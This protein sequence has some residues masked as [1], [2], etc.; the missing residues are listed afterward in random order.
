MDPRLSLGTQTMGLIAI[1]IMLKIRYGISLK[2]S[3]SS[4]SLMNTELI[5]KFT[6]LPE[7]LFQGW[8]WML[9]NTCLRIHRVWRRRPF[10]RTASAHV[11]QFH[12]RLEVHWRGNKM[13]RSLRRWWCP[14]TCKS[15]LQESTRRQHRWERRQRRC[16]NEA[17]LDFQFFPA[18]PPTLDN[19]SRC[20][21]DSWTMRRESTT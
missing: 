20:L 1:W 2:C 8:K 6:R 19:W 17:I 5:W 4:F 15:L 18:Q 10:A 16:T 21:S 7:G 11:A 13:D 12:W 14:T 9:D 3:F